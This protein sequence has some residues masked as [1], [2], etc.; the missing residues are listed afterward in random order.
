ML[1]DTRG[2]RRVATV[3]AVAAA[4]ESLVFGL[5]PHRSV[6]PE[7]GLIGLSVSVFFIGML[8]VAADGFSDARFYTAS[9]IG[10]FA[11]ILLPWRLA[12]EQLTRG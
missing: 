5:A 7:R 6:A 1:A 9:G 10:V 8:K 3:G 12:K 4:V 11:G 2:Q